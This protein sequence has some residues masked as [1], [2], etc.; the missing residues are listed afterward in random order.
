MRIKTCF[1]KLLFAFFTLEVCLSSSSAGHE[2]KAK[3]F[4]NK[5]LTAE[6]ISTG[7][8][9]SGVYLSEDQLRLGLADSALDVRAKGNFTH[10]G[11]V[12]YALQPVSAPLPPPT[13][14]WWDSP[15]KF[16]R[17]LFLY[18]VHDPQQISLSEA[19]QFNPADFS[20]PSLQAVYPLPISAN[21]LPASLNALESV[22]LANLV[23][24]A[25]GDSKGLCNCSANS[26]DLPGNSINSSHST[27]C[28]CCENAKG[29]MSGE[30][31][32]HADRTNCACH[33][34]CCNGENGDNAQAVNGEYIGYGGFGYGGFGSGGFGSGSGGMGGFSDFGLDGFGGGLG[35][36]GN[37]NSSSTGGG[38]NITPPISN[39]EPSTYV[40]LTS[41][42]I[43]FFL[44]SRRK[45]KLKV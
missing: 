44:I 35:S 2:I 6:D 8:S 28:A 22:R 12:G 36:F 21:D 45:K 37:G 25:K 9:S 34:F 41:L 39:P 29:G 10:M 43:G 19:I 18:L 27:A 15:L 24:E 1:Y 20:K 31:G 16:Q 13:N 42:L 11:Y 30:P 5:Y 14:D 32:E 3:K 33:D 26:R 40:I 4:I 17:G 38:G 7:G 23:G